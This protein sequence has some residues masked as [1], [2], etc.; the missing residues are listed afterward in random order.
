MKIERLKEIHSQLLSI[1][2]ELE[3][4]IYSDPEAYTLNIDYGEVLKYYETND[5][6]SD[7][8]L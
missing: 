3:S 2:R 8:G 4:E 5:D 7:E 1:V 6:D